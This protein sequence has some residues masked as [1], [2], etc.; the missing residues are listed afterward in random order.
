[1]ASADDHDDPNSEGTAR[2]MQMVA[3]AASVTEA[4]ARLKT[5]RIAE[6][7]GADQLVA[8][9]GRAQRLADHAAAG[10]A[11]TPVGDPEWLSKA[12][13]LDIGRGWG[14]AVPWAP[15]DPRAATAQAACEERLRELH[16]DAMRR[17]DWLRQ[18][19]VQPQAAMRRVAP[20]FAEG[21]DPRAWP[22]GPAAAP[23]ALSGGV[24]GLVVAE[25]GRAGDA[26]KAAATDLATPDRPA[27]TTV[28]EATAG[29]RAAVAHMNSADAATQRAADV[30]RTPAGVASEGYPLG[31]NHAATSAARRAAEGPAAST[32]TAARTGSRTHD[33][34]STRTTLPRAARR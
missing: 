3:M 26:R 31:V 12:S 30:S 9:A 10:M 5:Q 14:A 29:S 21:P 32:H 4:L 8:V 2:A 22:S 18:D 19:G 17:Y 20:L 13:T 25:R 33:H 6:R 23:T 11:W 28:N 16:P 24:D 27:T 15:T 7:Q 34:A 1:M